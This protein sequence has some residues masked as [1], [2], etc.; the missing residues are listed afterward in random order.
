M[1]QVTPPTR[2]N[3]RA[4]ANQT[5]IER[6]KMTD[7]INILAMERKAL[8][9]QHAKKDYLIARL[10]VRIA[11]LEQLIPRLNNDPRTGS[12]AVPLDPRD[13]STVTCYE[14]GIKGHYSNECPKKLMKAAN[15]APRDKSTVTCYECGVT[16]HYSYECPKKLMKAAPN[17]AAHAQQQRRVAAGRKFASGNSNNRNGRL[18]RMNATEAQEAPNVVMGMFSG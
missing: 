17:T 13:K 14:C 11:T 4:H 18:Y 3:S 12:N 1:I 10:R 16:G 5:H 8:R 7:T 15:N 9:H 6:A 2:N